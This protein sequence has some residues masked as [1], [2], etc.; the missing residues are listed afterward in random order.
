MLARSLRKHISFAGKTFLVV[1][2]GIVI[3]D[4]D[5]NGSYTT[6]IYSFGIYTIKYAFNFFIFYS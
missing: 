5:V 2:G 1:G 6:E 3:G 4:N